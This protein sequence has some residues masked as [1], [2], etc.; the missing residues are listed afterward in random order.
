MTRRVLHSL[1][2]VWARAWRT[3]ATRPP[4]TPSPATPVESRVCPDRPDDSQLVRLTTRFATAAALLVALAVPVAY[5]CHGYQEEVSRLE[6][7]LD[8]RALL[9]EE[10]VRQ[11]PAYWEFEVDK[12]ERVLRPGMADV[13]Q[14]D[15]VFDAS[16]RIVAQVPAFVT[17]E[18]PRAPMIVRSRGVVEGDRLVA[19]I[20][21]RASLL[22]LVRS[23][24]WA[25]ALSLLLAVGT[26]GLLTV[27]P[28]RALR[29]TIDR[30]GYLA[31]H[32]ALTGLPNLAL[33]R[34]R[35]QAAL[36]QIRRRNEKVA[37]LFIDLDHFKDVNDTFGHAVGDRLLR[38]AARRLRACI[39]ES[40]TLARFGGDE[41]AII[42]S[43][44]QQL[45]L[46]SALAQRLVDAF[47]EPFVLDGHHTSVGCSIGIAVAEPGDSDVDRLLRYADLALYQAK[48]QGRGTYRFFEKHLND[49]LQ[50]RKALEK[51]LRDALALGEDQFFLCYQPLVSLVDRRIIGVEAL[52]R[53]RHPQRGM[54]PPSEFI[55]IA[56]DCGLIVALGEWVLRTACARAVAWAPLFLA[57][58]LSPA[59]FRHA[60]LL[61]QIDGALAATGIAAERLELEITEGILM[62][63]TDATCATLEALKARGIRIA[64]DDFGT[65]YSSLS[66][67]RRFPFDK[68]KIDR[69]FVNDIGPAREANAIVR[70]IVALG[71]SL[72]MRTS[73]EGIETW[74]QYAYLN[75]IGCAE[76]QG[77]LFGKPASAA[78]IDALLP[79]IPDPAPALL[80]TAS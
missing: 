47:V 18:R 31:N 78:D 6:G 53:W 75:R 19:R 39:R 20:E 21:V 30:I 33:F 23:T 22:P 36:A 52:L 42:Q 16:G 12:L 28:L 45:T 40:D 7:E 61:D 58:N 29:G 14:I 26:Y 55:P 77:Y 27:I 46:A 11:R 57:V 25:I 49:R 50:A 34:D 60:G 66:Y 51:D 5:F 54:V 63:D 56:E 69:A 59:Q 67:L 68:I 17:E 72:N 80:L 48:G 13:R 71:Q 74:E 44:L 70:A 4:T 65:G 15:R 9:I 10:F 41:F 24:G 38:E 64:M 76:A 73:A 37:V 35:M 43:D 3:L 62:K 1:L 79:T 2:S 32:D 8:L